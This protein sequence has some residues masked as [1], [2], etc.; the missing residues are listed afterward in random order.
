MLRIL[1]SLLLITAYQLAAAQIGDDGLRAYYS[2]DG[3]DAIDETEGES[4]GT[5]FNG[6]GCACGISGN[7]LEFDGI[8]DYAVFFGF[9]NTYFDDD[10]FT[11]SFYYK[12]Y[13]S[14]FRR[15]LIAKKATC[16]NAS[17]L[18]IRLNQNQSK[19]I[20]EL[21]LTDQVRAIN[22]AD[23]NELACWQHVVVT[24][25]GTTFRTFINGQLADEAV[26]D[27]ILDVDNNA[28]LSIANSPCIGIDGTQ[29]FQGLIDEMR[30]Y[31]R[32]LSFSEI[33]GLYVL[34]DQIVNRDTLIFLGDSFE[35]SITET[36]AD[37]FMW[38]P[39]E[40]VTDPFSPNTR[41]SPIET[42]TYTLSFIDNLGCTALDTL[43]VEVV[44]PT[45]IPC[46]EIFIPSAFTPNN[47]GLN[48]VFRIS[49]PLSISELISFEVF[50]RWGTRVFLTNERQA[51]WD[52][53]FKGKLLDPGLYVYQVK[54]LC[55]NEA[56]RISGTVTI[57]N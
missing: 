27:L 47:D 17:N 28:I 6:V 46:T 25:R 29:R 38:S 44:D 13:N 24:R 8:D 51:G 48:D 55:E 4:D 43:R 19:V 45:S 32:A 56:K 23:V 21:S 1:L 31:N 35:T 57:L 37:E 15:S 34:P 2:F 39:L 22:E 49:N 20:A 36:C 11:L 16:S 14:S 53:T 42:T 26:S 50:D 3:C 41:L 12:S 40:G 30:V 52:G 9:V 18:E 33:E 10:D 7:A 5:L 54:F